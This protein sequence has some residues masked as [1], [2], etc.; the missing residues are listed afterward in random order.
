[1]KY[2][3]KCNLYPYMYTYTGTS[4]V[5]HIETITDSFTELYYNNDAI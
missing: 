2:S 3:R 1:M 5:K 4:Y